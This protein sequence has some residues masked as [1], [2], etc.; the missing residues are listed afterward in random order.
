M[1]QQVLETRR[2]VTGA[3]GDGNSRTPYITDIFFGLTTETPC[4]AKQSAYTDARYYVT[5]AIA[6]SAIA[7]ASYDASGTGTDDVNVQAD[8]MN[9]NAPRAACVTATNLAELPP[10]YASGATGGVGHGAHVLDSGVLVRDNGAGSHLLAS[11]SMVLVFGMRDV[12]NVMRKWYVFYQLPINK[13]IISGNSTR[14]GVYTANP[15][16]GT[17]AIFTSAGTAA[18]TLSD[19]G[20]T[21]S[22]TVL[23]VNQY[24][25]SKD[26][27]DPTQHDLASG[28]IFSGKYL[29]QDTSTPSKSVFLIE[30]V[31]YGNCSG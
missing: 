18:V 20:T 28:Q 12:S 3:L 26:P 7:E 11:G 25:M 22:A 31:A 21:G 16:N 10:G 1:R 27:A 8:P 30:G 23:L 13:F 2:I 17:T 24:E 9:N 19:I 5:R 29:C 14:P 4:S 6:P 15:L